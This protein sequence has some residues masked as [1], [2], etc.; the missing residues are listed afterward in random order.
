MTGVT[1]MTK[2][3]IKLAAMVVMVLSVGLGGTAAGAVKDMDPDLKKCLVKCDKEVQDSCKDPIDAIKKYGGK[4]FVDVT[5]EDNDGNPIG[6]TTVS[7]TNPSLT[8]DEL[9]CLTDALFAVYQAYQ[10][11]K[12]ACEQKI[13]APVN[14]RLEL[15][16]TK[17]TGE[18][19]RRLIPLGLT[20]LDL[21]SARVTDKGLREL[22]CLSTLK[23][24]E[25]KWAYVGFP[26]LQDFVNFSASLQALYLTG[27]TV[28][29]GEVNPDTS[30]PNC[31]LERVP[32][33]GLLAFLG[34]FDKLRGLD[35]GYLALTDDDLTALRRNPGHWRWLDLSQ[36]K[37]TNGCL[38]IV[39]QFEALWWLSFSGNSKFEDFG[40]SPL[41]QNSLDESLRRLNQRLKGAPITIPKAYSLATV[42]QV[43]GDLYSHR[44][45]DGV[46][47][48]V[49]AVSL[50][51]SQYSLDALNDMPQLLGL[52]IS[53]TGITNGGLIL[54]N[55]PQLNSLDISNTKTALNAAVLD[56]RDEIFWVQIGVRPAILIPVPI[57]MPH[58]YTKLQ[59]L[60]LDQTALSDDELPAIATLAN[61]N[62]RLSLTGTVVTPK[63]LEQFVQ[64][65]RSITGGPA[66]TLIDDDLTPAQ[67]KRLEFLAS[68]RQGE[69][70]PPQATRGKR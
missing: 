65:T 47:E 62:K 32:G 2:T 34:S 10:N 38:P 67:F 25:I 30:T 5:D 14:N 46:Q 21:T 48:R 52:D 58:R 22:A 16:F 28:A 41:L 29:N 17:V 24:L 35:L 9:L 15:R 42:Y 36:N 59:S 31:K 53:S 43:L 40:I 20:Q 56:I 45:E 12:N 4:V 44:W 63:N 7:F 26:A 66:F 37:L 69:F 27:I 49:E 55:L 60:Y 6:T 54:I 33:N 57:P 8:D 68:R 39:S 11:C 51:L 64:T 61:I 50:I 13:P 23:D 70:K 1:P 18:G 19:F 3:A